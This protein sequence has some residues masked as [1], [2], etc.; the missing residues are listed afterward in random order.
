MYFPYDVL[1]GLVFL[2]DRINRLFE[3]RLRNVYSVDKA[4]SETGW[5]PAVDIYETAGEIFL[6]AEL[7]GV[8]LEN[9]QVE[10]A[11]SEL[12]LKGYRP[13]PREGL[14]KEFY[15]RLECG[16]GRFERRFTL[17]TIV[18]SDEITARVKD[19]VLM[20]VVPKKKGQ[21][22]TRIEID[23]RGGEGN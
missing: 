12:I 23:K 21:K 10:V 13:F 9:I 8:A 2:Q 3:E 17:S 18:E 20:V 14:K 4:E 1:K 7:P 16:Y 19:G 6:S 5:S 11:G 15:Q 22:V